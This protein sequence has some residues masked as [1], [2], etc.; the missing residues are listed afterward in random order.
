MFASSSVHTNL[1]KS[2]SRERCNKLVWLVR[3]DTDSLADE[4]EES[5]VDS[6]SSDAESEDVL[7]AV[8]VAEVEHD[9]VRR[10]PVRMT[11]SVGGFSDLEGM[12][13]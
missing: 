3:C 2:P 1:S 6:E 13:M 10:A 12:S 9:K 8:E 7:P 4:D 5:V 11:L